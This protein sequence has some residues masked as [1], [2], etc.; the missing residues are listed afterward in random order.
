MGLPPSECSISRS[1]SVARVPSDYVLRAAQVDRRED[2][3]WEVVHRPGERDPEEH[4]PVW[5]RLTGPVLVPTLGSII[6]APRK[7]PA[8]RAYSRGRPTTHSKP[9]DSKRVEF[10]LVT[11]PGAV[12]S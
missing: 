4:C 2:G 11:D 7:K 5:R 8:R 6:S 12:E 10:D 3:E 1:A 9:F